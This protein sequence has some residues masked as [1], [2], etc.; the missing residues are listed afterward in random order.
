M[1]VQLQLLGTM[2]AALGG[3]FLAFRF[4]GGW[5][6]IGI[7]AVLAV[8]Y[9]LLVAAWAENGFERLDVRVLLRRDAWRFRDPRRRPPV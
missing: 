1:R 5:V 3:L 8:I 2:A 9:L 4:V 7:G 6:G